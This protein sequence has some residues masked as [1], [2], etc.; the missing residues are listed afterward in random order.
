MKNGVL[1]VIAKQRSRCIHPGIIVA[2]EVGHW[3]LTRRL[4]S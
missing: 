4:R 2:V 1:K 3:R